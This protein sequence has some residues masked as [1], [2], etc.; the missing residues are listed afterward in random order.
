M[1]GPSAGKANGVAIAPDPFAA[2]ANGVVADTAKDAQGHFDVLH[3]PAIVE[4]IDA[5]DLVPVADLGTGTWARV[6]EC[7]LHGKAVAVKRLHTNNLNPREVAGFVREGVLIAKLNHQFIVHM[8][9]LGF[10]IDSSNPDPETLFM[11]EEL[12]SGGTLRDKLHSQMHAYNKVVYT[13]MEAL[14]WCTQLASALAYLHAQRPMIIHRDLKLDNVLL[15]DRTAD[16]EVK[17]ADFGL[18]AIVTV[19]GLECVSHE[20]TAETGSALNMAPE[21]KKGEFYNEKVDIFSLGCCIFEVFSKSLAS[22]EIGAGNTPEG[23]Q[24]AALSFSRDVSSGFRRPIP[25]TWPPALRDVV[26]DCWQQDPK[27]RPSALEVMERLEDPQLSSAVEEMDMRGHGG[28]G[29]VVQ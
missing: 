12:C 11:V 6:D 29:C 25:S 24:R 9:G 22:S 20:L 10:H 28:C 18:C 16:A 5:K 8:V 13:Y 23:K 14:R 7:K 3:E 4:I 1:A 26:A 15:A 21:M 17:L 27:L 19:T 2:I